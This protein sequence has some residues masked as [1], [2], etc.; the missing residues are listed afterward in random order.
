MLTV[1]LNAAPVFDQLCWCRG[2]RSVVE[3]ALA[4]EISR[5]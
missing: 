3:L 1:R 4:G 5:S 2:F